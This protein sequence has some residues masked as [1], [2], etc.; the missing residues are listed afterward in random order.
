MML[1]TPPFEIS[2]LIIVRITVFVVNFQHPQT[3]LSAPPVNAFQLMVTPGNAPVINSRSLGHRYTN[4]S[5][6]SRYTQHVAC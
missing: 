2:G 4:P 5:G 3:A 1:S 6:R